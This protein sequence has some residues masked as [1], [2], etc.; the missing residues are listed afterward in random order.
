MRLGSATYSPNRTRC[1]AFV[2]GFTIAAAA[3][4]LAL[5]VDFRSLVTRGKRTARS[6]ILQGLCWFLIETVG[7]QARHYLVYC[8]TRISPVSSGRKAY[9]LIRC[10]SP[11]P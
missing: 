9:G 7:P 5:L 3:R 2:G 10:I 11:G 1:C 6:S 4:S 8:K